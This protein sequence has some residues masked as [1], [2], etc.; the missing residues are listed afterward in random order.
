MTSPGIELA[1]FKSVA[2]CLNQLHYLLCPHVLVWGSTNRF[3][4]SML[5]TVSTSTH[6]NKTNSVGLSPRA[7]YTDWS[8][9]TCQR[10][11]VSTF[12]DRGVSRCQRG[13]SPTVVNLSF[14]DRT[15][16]HRFPKCTQHSTYDYIRKICKKQAYVVQN[17]LNPTVRADGQEPLRI[18]VGRRVGFNSTEVK[19][20]FVRTSKCRFRV[21]K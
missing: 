11:L 7:N 21:V 4:F 3:E 10:N 16:T 15:G 12:V 18:C 19:T 5:L 17:H 13:G 1:T 9:A 6:T 2:K 14:L 20:T 8:T